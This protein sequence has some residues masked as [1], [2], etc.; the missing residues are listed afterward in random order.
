[1][2]I[3]VE[4]GTEIGAYFVNFTHVRKGKNYH[5]YIRMDDIK[6]F[7]SDLKSQNRATR[8]RLETTSGDV[9]YTLNS[10]I[11]IMDT[12]RWYPQHREGKKTGFVMNEI[13]YRP[14]EAK[15]T[16]GRENYE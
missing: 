16:Q 14:E 2:K 4:G 9:Y 7:D 3:N 15:K 11:D 5:V 13:L 12:N 1:M 10:F 8:W 6:S